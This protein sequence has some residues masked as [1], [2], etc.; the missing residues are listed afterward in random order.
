MLERMEF[1]GIDA[2]GIENYALI[3][4]K[5]NATATSFTLSGMKGKRVLALAFSWYNSNSYASTRFDGAT[6]TGG[7]INKIC[8]LLDVTARTQGTYYNLDIT[9]DECVVTVPATC[10][11]K[12]FEAEGKIIPSQQQVKTGKFTTNTTDTTGYKVTLGFKPKYICCV[13]SDGSTGGA[14]VYN[15]DVGVNKYERSVGQSNSWINIGETPQYLG[16]VSIDTDGFTIYTGSTWSYSTIE[17]AY[18]AIGE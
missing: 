18:F 3:Y 11:L 2:G 1:G 9:S 16:F 8:N 12:V 7:T 6:A 13:A 15:K 10:Y 14:C 17:W 4:N 5:T